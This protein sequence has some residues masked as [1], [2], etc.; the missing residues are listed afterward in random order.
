VILMLPLVS[1]GG[2]GRQA[3]I[4]NKER[5][6]SARKTVLFL[7]GHIIQPQRRRQLTQGSRRRGLS[8]AASAQKGGLPKNTYV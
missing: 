3:L 2:L 5:I 1:A 7:I 6:V 4:T 8:T